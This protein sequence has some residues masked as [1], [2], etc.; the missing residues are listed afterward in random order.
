MRQLMVNILQNHTKL[1]WPDQCPTLGL[2]R[3]Q[4]QRPFAW[5]FHASLGSLKVMVTKPK[6]T[7][8]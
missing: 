6:E 1:D 5:W 8:Q 4:N 3:Y 2:Y 7:S